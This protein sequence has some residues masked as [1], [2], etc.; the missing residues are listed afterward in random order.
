MRKKVSRADV[1]KAAGVAESTVSRALNDS[2]LISEEVKE[3]IKKIASDLGYIPNR[4]AVLLASNKT[5]RV[6]LVVPTYKSFSPFTR[7]YFP[8]LL[9]GVLQKAEELGYTV[10]I[11][12]DKKN[13][14][15]KDL[16]EMIY[17]KEVDGF[18]FSVTSLADTRFK[19]LLSHKVPFVLLNNYVAG[20]DCINCDPYVGTKDALSHLAKMGHQHI[21]YIMGDINYWDGK[22]RLAIFQKLCA[23]MGLR[24]TLTD[25][26]FSKRSGLAGAEELLGLS[27]VPTAILAGS[28]RC[29]LGVMEYCKKEDIRIPEEISLIGFDNLGPA[30]DAVPGL[31][32]IHNPVVRMASD[33][34]DLLNRRLNGENKKETSHLVDSGFIIRKS[35]GVPHER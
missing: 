12:L 17:S 21:G 11:V 7:S 6:G 23:E 3:K 26:N 1:A 33:A 18:I 32:T 10:T 14:Q 5:M 16:S 29:A 25:G 2:T 31:S 4:Q 34:M 9:D 35:T 27:D 13:D 24:Y 8:R 19:D 15:Y 28:D 30:R 20:A 22:E